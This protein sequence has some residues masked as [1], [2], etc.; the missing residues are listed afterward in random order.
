MVQGKFLRKDG[1]DH[2]S[3]ACWAVGLVGVAVIAF[4]HMQSMAASAVGAEFE[5]GRRAHYEAARQVEAS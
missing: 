1:S 3:A 2:I 4:L 5:E